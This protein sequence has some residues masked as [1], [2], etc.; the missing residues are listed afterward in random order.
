[1]MSPMPIIQS[2]IKRN[3]QAQKNR[4]YNT[5]VKVAV[6]KKTK[7]VRDVIAAGTIK[8]E[9]ELVAAISE[10]DRAVKKGVLHKSTAARRKS[11]LTLAYNGAAPAAYGTGRATAKKATTKKA[12][13]KK[14]AAKKPTT[15]K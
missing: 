12:A 7:A 6:H 10:I 11:R 1:M 8:T 4:V 14:P 13:T 9:A 5:N 2:A 15:K 3:R